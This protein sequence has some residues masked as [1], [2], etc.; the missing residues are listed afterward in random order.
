MGELPAR[1]TLRMHH[2][3]VL[4]PNGCLKPPVGSACIGGGGGGGAGADRRSWAL[5]RRGAAPGGFFMKIGCPGR[6]S[7]GGMLGPAGELHASP[8]SECAS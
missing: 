1:R 8:N 3:G 5:P 7:C 4:G 2:R 6:Q